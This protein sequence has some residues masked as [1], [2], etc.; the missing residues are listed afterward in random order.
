MNQ[1]NHDCDHDEHIHTS[2]IESNQG[3]RY[4][5][6][7]KTKHWNKSQHKNKYRNGRYKREGFTVIK[8]SNQKQSER[9]QYRIY[10]GNYRLCFE[11]QTKSLGDFFGKIGK[12]FINK[13]EVSHFNARKVM[14]DLFSINQKHKTQDQ[15]YNH[16]K[17][18]NSS[19]FEILKNAH[20]GSLQIDF[21]YH[22]LEKSIETKIEAHLAL[23][24][25]SSA[26]QLIS[27]LGS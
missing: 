10:Q 1:N 24:R 2:Q 13:S 27:N 11:N 14:I 18:E 15:R 26:P 9:G 6:N 22:T 17:Y 20:D 25:I 7:Q 19:I 4:R 16:L 5:R 3:N 12:L 8:I 23:K 21:A